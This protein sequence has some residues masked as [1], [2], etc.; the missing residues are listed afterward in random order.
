MWISIEKR[1]SLNYELLGKWF[2]LGDCLAYAYGND[3]F[4]LGLQRVSAHKSVS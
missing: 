2:K 3:V 1:E 4:G